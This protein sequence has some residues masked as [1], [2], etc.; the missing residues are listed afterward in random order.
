[1]R[2][3]AKKTVL[4]SGLLRLAAG[5]C[6]P[7]AAI[8]MYHSVMESPA[9]QDN[10]LGGIVHSQN[11]F[12]QQ[13]ELLARHYRPVSLDQIKKFVRGEGEI[14]DRAVAVTFDDGYADNCEIAAPILSEVGVPATVYVVVD[15]IA[16]AK[17][18][19]PA[20]LRF[21]FRTTK[22][23]RWYEPAGNGWPLHDRAEREHAYLY[24]CDECCQLTG[25][26][27]ERYV[28]RVEFELDARVPCE[29]GA[30]MMNYDQVRGLLRQGHSVGSHTLSHPNLAHVGL[31]EAR[32][33]FADSKRHLEQ[34]LKMT[35]L[36]FSYPCPARPPNWTAATVEESRKAGY[37]TAVTTDNGIVRKLDDPLRWKRIPPTKTVEGLRWNLERA[38]ASRAV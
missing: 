29:A 31:P 4:G 34:Q 10:L 32:V 25:E 8:L 9:V 21:S 37:E 2:D 22:K 19:W 35:V 12:H 6:G 7:G 28:A 1:M 26:T 33:E 16:Q 27:Q 13:M 3:L 36:H 15:C 5:F 17:L 11:V 24:A 23:E 14:P 20:R 18:P 38:F 30:L